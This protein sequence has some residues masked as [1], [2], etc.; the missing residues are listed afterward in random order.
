MTAPIV[1][2]DKIWE[3]VLEGLSSKGRLARYFR[4]PR[5]ERRAIT[6]LFGRR[7]TIDLGKVFGFIQEG[8][9]AECERFIGGLDEYRVYAMIQILVRSMQCWAE[10][11]NVIHQKAPRRWKVAHA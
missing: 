6:Q 3:D 1:L 11:D 9:F 4:L 5:H 2:R 8:E 7:S 10:T